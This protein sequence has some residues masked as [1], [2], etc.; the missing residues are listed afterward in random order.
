[1]KKEIAEAVRSKNEAEREALD[2]LTLAMK[3]GL[4][5]IGVE[6]EGEDQDTG[7]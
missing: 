7:D 3:R 1:M 6:V 5:R 2:M 4:I